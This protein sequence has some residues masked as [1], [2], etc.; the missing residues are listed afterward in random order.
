[1]TNYPDLPWKGKKQAATY[2]LEGSPGEHEPHVIGK[3]VVRTR[4]RGRSLEDSSDFR[5]LHWCLGLTLERWQEEFRLVERR[6]SLFRPFAE[7]PFFGFRGVVSRMAKR[8]GVKFAEFSMCT[9]IIRI[10]LARG[11]WG[12]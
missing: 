6:F 2:M 11:G 4:A 8:N 1:M 7:S 12:K 3:L 10:P 9:A 5:W